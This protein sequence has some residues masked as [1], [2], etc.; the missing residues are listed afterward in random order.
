MPRFVLYDG[1]SAGY[2]VDATDLSL[3]QTWLYH[4]CPRLAGYGPMSLTAEP[5]H[6]PAGVPD[7]P[8]EPKYYGERFAIAP[9]PEVVME[10]IARRRE[11]LEAE[12]DR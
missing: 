11:E 2:R 8:A 12:L 1:T 7:W 5:L 10:Q 6:D 3:V 9:D 4:W